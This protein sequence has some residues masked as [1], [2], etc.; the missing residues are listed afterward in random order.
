[1]SVT[2]NSARWLEECPVKGSPFLHEHQLQPARRRCLDLRPPGPPGPPKANQAMRA[3]RDQLSALGGA[4]IE[5]LT[6]TE[7]RRQP[8]P[9]DAVRALL[10]SRG[11]VTHR[12]RWLKSPTNRSLDLVETF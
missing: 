3:V 4:P 11:S 8:S 10:K 2:S 7:A 1:V 9:A 12:N 6:S 5:T